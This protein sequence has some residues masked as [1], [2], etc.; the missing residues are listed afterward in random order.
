[1]KRVVVICDGCIYKCENG[2]SFPINLSKS[3]HN[4]LSIIKKF[5][6][7]NI[8]IER[9]VM[10][11]EDGILYRVTSIFELSKYLPKS[12]GV[13]QCI[14]IGKRFKPIIKVEIIGIN[15]DKSSGYILLDKYSN[16][17][18]NIKCNK[19]ISKRRSMVYYGDL[20]VDEGGILKWLNY[21][22][23]LKEM[24]ILKESSENSK[25]YE[26]NDFSF[27]CFTPPAEYN[28]NNPDKNAK[29]IIKIYKNIKGKYAESDE[30]YKV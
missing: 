16:K 29:T 12:G 4:S 17:Y 25:V 26:K 8:R 23:I 22:I 2:S 3:K 20:F 10:N 9:K 28:P 24:G 7:V 15:E 18:S 11:T 27:G 30:K 21:G 14:I 1:M 13:L 19:I 5:S 6:E